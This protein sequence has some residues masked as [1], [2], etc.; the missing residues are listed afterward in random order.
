V[1]NLLDLSLRRFLLHE[2]GFADDDL[3]VTF[4]APDSDWGARVTRATVNLFLWDLR[5]N[6]SEAHSGSE[7]VVGAD[8]VRVRRP[9]LP[10]VDCRYLVTAWTADVADEHEILGDLLRILLPAT[11]LREEHC[12]PALAAIKPLP[13]LQ[14]A[15]PDTRDAADFWS[16]LGG[17]LRPG[18]DLL[19]TAVVPTGPSV[20]VGT[21]VRRRGVRMAEL[22]RPAP[23]DPWS[24]PVDADGDEPAVG[25]RR[26]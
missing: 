9:P 14:A 15:L 25:E 22:P 4:D 26:D 21:S 24:K 8:G 19:V 16:A 13:T 20:P 5:R 12:E 6:Q 11:T 1:I 10:R 17:Q 7:T 23:K 18:L 3:D 2:L